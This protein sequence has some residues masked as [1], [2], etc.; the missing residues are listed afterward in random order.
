MR[1]RAIRKL[2]PNVVTINAGVDARDKDGNGIE[3]DN[4]LIDQKVIELKEIDN[5]NIYKKKRALS[6]DPITEQLD[7]QY[8]DSVNGT[9]IWKDRISAVK[10]LYPKP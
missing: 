4:S 8:W 6:F 2:Y 9:T 3:L 1:D 7:Q 10:D 5:S